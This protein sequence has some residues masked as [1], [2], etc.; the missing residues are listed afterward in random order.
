LHNLEYLAK[1]DNLYDKVPENIWKEYRVAKK[2]LKDDSFLLLKVKNNKNF[3]PKYQLK[4]F[5]RI[6]HFLV[7]SIKIYELLVKNKNT[8]K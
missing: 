1:H 4:E 3:M 2:N 6:F 5:D 8:K 7:I